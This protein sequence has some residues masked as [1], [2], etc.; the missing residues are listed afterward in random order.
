MTLPSGDSPCEMTLD[1]CCNVVHDIANHLLT[2]IH[3]AILPCYGDA[4]C[5][6]APIKYV[7]FGQGDD[8]IRDALTVAILSA[9]PSP[10][11]QTG[12]GGVTIPL[13]LYRCLFE[14]RLR[15]SG[16]PMA[17]IDGN[18]IVPPDPERQHVA[19]RHAFAHGEMMY[20]KINSMNYNRT[21]TPTTVAPFSK[22]TIGQLLP[23]QPLGGVVGFAF[24]VAIDLPWNWGGG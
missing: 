16:W 13:G 10:I 21:L 5:N 7:T 1:A 2:S 22:A 19:T 24:Q 15:E 8:G 18:Q 9:G 17:F 20:R 6:E 4:M 12:A 3:D 14:V 11:T 23:L